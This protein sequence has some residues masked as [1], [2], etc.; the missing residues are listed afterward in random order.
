MPRIALSYRRQDSAAI[1]GR[2]FDRLC[3]HYGKDSV[4][5]DVDSIPYGTD[6]R[7]HIQKVWQQTDVV[8]AVIG[9]HWL[10]TNEAGAV[11]LSEESDP[12][13]QEIETALELEMPLL[14]VL[15][16]G[17]KM[18]AA[19]TVP[20]SLG[21]FPF[22]NAAEVSSGRDFHVHVDRLIAAI[23]RALA[24]RAGDTARTGGMTG[25]LAASR[26]ASAAAPTFAG[27]PADLVRYL[28]VPLVLVLVAQH[29]IDIFDLDNA[30]LRAV[31]IVLPFGFG[32]ALAWFGNR[33]ISAAVAVA[34]ALGILATSGMTLSVSL[35]SGDTMLP[36]N[37]YE[38]W[39][40]AEYII[41]IA[42]GFIA[43]HLAAHALRAAQRSRQGK[44][45]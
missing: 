40:N 16:D 32:F 13:R 45:P 23:D 15:V 3:A 26:L 34:V 19:T 42:L 35:E 8:I 28:I 27:W 31:A 9:Q 4:F 24:E 30:Y 37:R 44:A 29:L 1:T 36:E 39:S 21:D 6:F 14:P 33:G 12:V 11:R 22:F 5:I 18:P 17:A 10:G 43:G 38:W 7:T 41:T 25:G 2:I 20:E